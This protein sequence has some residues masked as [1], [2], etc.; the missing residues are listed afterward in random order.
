MSLPTEH[1]EH[2]VLIHSHWI[3]SVYSVYSVGQPD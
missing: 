3:F 2:T 1:T